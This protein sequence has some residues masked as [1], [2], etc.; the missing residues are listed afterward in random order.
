MRV[1]VHLARGSQCLKQVAHELALTFVEGKVLSG[2]REGLLIK[3]L[4]VACL[5][6]QNNGRGAVAGMIV[7]I[8]RRFE[9]SSLLA[10]DQPVTV[11]RKNF[12]YFFYVLC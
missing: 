8:Q 3:A 9:A 11:Y 7:R 1:S 12:R 6:F 10:T 5:G 4:L 2:D